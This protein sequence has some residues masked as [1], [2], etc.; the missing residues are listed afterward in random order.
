MKA[1]INFT[2]TVC[3]LL[4]SCRTAEI[5]RSVGK[6]DNDGI[7]CVHG[8]KNSDG[9]SAESINLTDYRIS[10]DSC[11][12]LH[13]QPLPVSSPDRTAKEHV[14]TAFNWADFD[15]IHEGGSILIR[16][17]GRPVFTFDTTF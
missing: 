17:K 11:S 8:Q 7:G 6:A 15:T 14:D 13:R 1:L 9:T 2:M 16:Y 5:D 10:S 12:W 3:L 4:L